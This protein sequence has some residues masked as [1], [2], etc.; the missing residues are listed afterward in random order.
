MERFSDYDDYPIIIDDIVKADARNIELI[1][2][3]NRKNR[4]IIWIKKGERIFVE[5][6]VLP[7]WMVWGLSN[8]KVSLKN[9]WGYIIDK[10][11][12][13]YLHQLSERKDLIK[14]VHNCVYV[15]RGSN[16]RLTN[17]LEIIKYLSMHEFEIFYPDSASFIDE[18]EIFSTANC[19]V[20]CAGAA[21]TNL[22][23]CKPS[24]DVFCILPFEF[25]IDTS[26]DI[27]STVGVTTHMVDAKILENSGFLMKSKIYLP[28][29]KC[30]T[31]VEYCRRKHYIK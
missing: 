22:A 26:N 11:A 24:V 27:S 8:V 31:I 29:S 30:E 1:N 2:L 14:R 16:D 12:G 17:E 4:S 10:R 19:I 28:L 21:S 25:R 6:L 3:L 20:L 13:E 23:F 5:K 9:N 18:L 15:A 7:P